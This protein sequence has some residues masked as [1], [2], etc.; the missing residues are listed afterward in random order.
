VFV[1][2]WRVASLPAVFALPAGYG[3]MAIGATA[4]LVAWKVSE[5]AH[6]SGFIFWQALGITDLVL[7]VGLGATARMLSPNRAP[8]WPP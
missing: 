3:D 6:R 4:A 8:R 2:G 7:A 5:Y 1:I